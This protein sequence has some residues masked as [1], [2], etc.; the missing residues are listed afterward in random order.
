MM[1]NKRGEGASKKTKGRKRKKEK[2][3]RK[4]KRN[5]GNSCA[6]LVCSE[7]QVQFSRLGVHR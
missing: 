3:K 7:Q 2:P 4:R 5:C 6:D 1:N